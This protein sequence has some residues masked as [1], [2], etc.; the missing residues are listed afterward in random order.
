MG[1]A[2]ESFLMGE[3]RVRGGGV[4]RTRRTFDGKADPIGVAGST[5]T[6][7]WGDLAFGGG[8]EIAD[9]VIEFAEEVEDALEWCARCRLRI[10]DTEDDVDLRPLNPEDLL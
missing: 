5:L 7:L 4:V 1:P 2:S 8:L 3:L 9:E 6:E 10:D